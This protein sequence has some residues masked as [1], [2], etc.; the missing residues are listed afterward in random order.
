MGRGILARRKRGSVES[1]GYG[2]GGMNVR[3]G[4]RAGWGSL[5]MGVGWQES[6]RKCKRKKKI[7]ACG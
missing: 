5:K 7:W 3:C 1:V 2:R 6:I 4:G